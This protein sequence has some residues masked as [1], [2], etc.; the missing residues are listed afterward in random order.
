MVHGHAK[1]IN[2]DQTRGREEMIALKE[3]S[4]D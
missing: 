3:K 4:E 1:I 2:G